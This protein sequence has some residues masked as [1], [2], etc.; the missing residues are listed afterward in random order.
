MDNTEEKLPIELTADEVKQYESKCE[1][2]QKKYE[3]PKI[4][5]CVQYKPDGLNTRVVSYLREPSFDQQLALMS[6]LREDN[7][8]EIANEMRELFL[9]KDES[10][11]LTYGNSYECNPY[12][13]GVVEKFISI[14]TIIRD[15]F[16]KK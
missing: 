9:L 3:C 16:K 13:L 10:D 11:P 12:K 15:K 7:S 4:H 14:F 5:V 6:K 1:E 8:Y 2:L